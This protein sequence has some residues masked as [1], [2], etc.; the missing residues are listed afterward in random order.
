MS[1]Q[2]LQNIQNIY[3]ISLTL[4][5]GPVLNTLVRKSSDLPNPQCSNAFS[6]SSNCKTFALQVRNTYFC[7]ALCRNKANRD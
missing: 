5:A 2:W 4:C 3:S 7:W 6:F 1:P